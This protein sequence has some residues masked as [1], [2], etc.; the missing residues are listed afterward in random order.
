LG[1]NPTPLIVVSTGTLRDV[2]LVKRPTLE[3]MVGG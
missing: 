1:S 3:S 2:L